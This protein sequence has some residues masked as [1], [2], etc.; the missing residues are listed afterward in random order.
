MSKKSQLLQKQ[1]HQRKF[2]K[3]PLPNNAEL[4]RH[5]EYLGGKPL[6][7]LAGKCITKT[8]LYTSLHIP[9][10]IGVPLISGMGFC[11]HFYRPQR[12]CE[13]Y[14]FYRCLSVHEG[15]G[16]GLP[17]CVPGYT[18][19][20]LG[21]HPPQTPPPS[22]RLLLRTVRILLECILVIIAVAIPIPP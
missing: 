19:P 5:L 12:S 4:S 13:G 18:S 10:A 9:I 7:N 22:R 1:S 21:R 15:G 16:Q 6:L 17:Q 2:Q 14:V 8:Q 20:S 3:L 11:T